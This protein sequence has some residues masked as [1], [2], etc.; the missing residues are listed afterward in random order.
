MQ[1]MPTSTAVISNSPPDGHQICAV[2]VAW[3]L[4]WSHGRTF[5]ATT[6]TK[7]PK[8]PNLKQKVLGQR[9][10]ELQIS[11]RDLL[12]SYNILSQTEPYGPEVFR[13]RDVPNSCP[14]RQILPT[15]KKHV[16]LVSSEIF[17]FCYLE[18]SSYVALHS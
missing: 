16:F 4:L 14:R 6:T 7:L 5:P 12:K 10:S 17:S 8:L 15:K 18:R 13:E 3:Q 1:L 9:M 11:H 2:A